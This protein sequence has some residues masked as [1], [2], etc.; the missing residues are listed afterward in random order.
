M[1]IIIFLIWVMQSLCSDPLYRFELKGKAQ[2]TTWAVIYY[3]KDSVIQKKTCD[4]LLAS[5]DSSLSIYK[6][7]SRINALNQA[8]KTYTA[9]QHLIAVLTMGQQVARTTGGAF[10]MTILPLVQAWGFGA[11]QHTSPPDTAT[12]I[13]L[14]NCTGYRRLQIRKN[15]IIKQKPCV[16]ID[17]NG[18]AQGYS[19]D[20]LARFL[21]TKGVENYLVEIGGEL[22]VR[23]RRQP[24]GEAFTVGIESPEAAESFG[25]PLQKKIHLRSGA[26]TTS[27]SY[28]RYYLQGDKAISHLLDPRTGFA[29]RNDLL[30]VTVWAPNAI[31]AD[32]WDNALMVMGLDKALSILERHN[33]LAAYFIFKKADG[34]I[35]DTAST[36]FN[37][38]F[39]M[40]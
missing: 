23:G 16:Q 35:G 24:S 26:L 15:K 13:A 25:A 14:K 21:D 38:L 3:A 10:D 31:I 18:I 2:G 29:L 9:D 30:S 40:K 12:I 19:V 36:N 7:Y 17:V 8:Q 37:K 27:G 33:D 6:P 5:L 1:Q 20:V 11:R 28:R 22:R 39:G 34:S 4:S 32:A